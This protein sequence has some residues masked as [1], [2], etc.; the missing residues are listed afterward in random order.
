MIQRMPSWMVF[1]ALMAL[2]GASP[3]GGGQETV[4]TKQ[5]AVRFGEAGIT[6][7]KRINDAFDTDYI[8]EGETLGHVRVRYRMP[9]QP[10]RTFSSSDPKER[11]AS[12]PE[13][14]GGCPGLTVAYNESEWN[15]YYAD[16][17]VAERFRVEDGALYWT[18]HLRNL[19]HKPLELGDVALS[20]PFNS[21]MRWDKTISTTKRVVDHPFISGHGSFLF[22]MRPNG[23][24]PYLVMTPVSICPLFES[25]RNERNFRPAKLEY[26]DGSGFYIHA[27]SVVADAIAKGG[28]WRQP[29]TSALLSPKFSPNDE[30]TYSFKF[31]WADG[32][33][34]VRNVLV[35]EGLFDVNVVPGMTVPVDLEAK[36]AIRTK[37]MFTMVPE[38]PEETKLDE[39]DGKGDGTRIF[40]AHFSKLGENKLT[41]RFGRD[42]YMILEFFV[43]EPLETLIKKRAAFLVKKQQHRDPAKW[44]NGLFSEWD[45]KNEVL[46]SPDDTDGLLD[47]ILTCDDPGLCKA[48]YVAAKNVHYPDAGEIAAVEYYLKNFVWGKLQMTDRE[49]YPYAVYG[50][51]NWKINRESRPADRNGWTGHLWRVF[52]YP[53]VIHLYWS[54]A[55]IAKNYPDLVKYLNKDGYLERAYGTAM[56]Y[57]TVPLKLAGWSACDLG[58]YDE[59][60]IPS[61]IEDLDAAG[62][63]DK[64]AHLRKEWEKK[65]EHFVND[66]PDLF[67]SEFPFDPTGFESHQA[68]SRYVGRELGK[69]ITSLRVKAPDLERFTAEELT[70]NIATRG[71]LETAYHRLGCEGE[72]RYMS[73]MGG[74]AL[75]DNALYQAEDPAP[76]LRLGYASILSSWALVNSG[77]PETNYGFWFP[78]PGNDGGAGSAFIREIYGTNWFGKAQK[79]GAWIYGG[80][81]DLGF[82]GALRA[83]A[84]IVTEDPIFGLVAYGGEVSKNGKTFLVVPRDGLRKRFHAVFGKDR[85]HLILDRDGFAAGTQVKIDRAMS[86]ISFDLE[87]RSGDNH[88]TNLVLSGRP[89]GRFR[90][91]L[92]GKPTGS[93]TINEDENAV[94]LPVKAAGTSKVVLRKGLAGEVST[95]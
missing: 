14:E 58:N 55:R 21:E 77:R 89:G 90:I 70:G 25:V 51:D 68:F 33:E 85:L 52:D 47:Y 72:M 18:L 63:P 27:S 93:V 5:F 86:E 16:I 54:M 92:D 62:W 28:T 37:N 8:Q 32:Y 40:K 39:L 74:W 80:E 82:G 23:E 64:A 46:R 34:G 15:D 87:N 43:T 95:E 19:T 78:G 30:I 10:W 48:P 83:A 29:A 67:Y 24:G 45:M 44:F 20:L 4:T 17:E 71:W 7:L 56:A 3:T 65:V 73:Q 94:I 91:F 84:A 75:L 79:R 88:K 81:I 57:F 35:D 12:R 61:L 59:V 66:G 13:V 36:I 22:W 1:V 38:F 6:S 26:A 2:F 76:L 42:Q 53:H 50:I 41:V 49:P 69:P 60:V 31:R 11:R 9:G